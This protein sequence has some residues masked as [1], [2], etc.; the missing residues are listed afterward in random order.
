M[1]YLKLVYAGNKEAASQIL[2]IHTYYMFIAIMPNEFELFS[3][4]EYNC[5]PANPLKF[6]LSKLL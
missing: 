6:I 1:L 2:H 4:Q 5:L 3:L